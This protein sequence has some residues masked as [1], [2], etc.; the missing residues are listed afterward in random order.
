MNHFFHHLLKKKKKNPQKNQFWVIYPQRQQLYLERVAKFQTQAGCHHRLVH[1]NIHLRFICTS[2]FSHYTRMY[3]T[4]FSPDPDLMKYSMV[5]LLYLLISSGVHLL[6][7]TLKIDLKTRADHT[8]VAKLQQLSAA[9]RCSSK[10]GACSALFSFSDERKR[11]AASVN[12]SASPGAL[13][14]VCSHLQSRHRGC[15]TTADRSLS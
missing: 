8:L 11:R 15:I 13:K 3:S 1:L 5:N 6:H 4:I 2:E 7:Q 10:P 9:W 12:A 14:R